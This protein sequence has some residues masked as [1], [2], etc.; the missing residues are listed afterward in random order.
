[1][2]VYHR[3]A[4]VVIAMLS[5][6][7]PAATGVSQTASE[8]ER[9]LVPI[10]LPYDQ[11]T[12]GAYGSVWQTE[13]VVRNETDAPAVIFQ[14]LCTYECR[15]PIP[16]TACSKGEPTQP[17]HTFTGVLTPDE[18]AVNPAIFLHV[19]K[20]IAN[21]G[22]MNLRLWERSRGTV[23]SGVEVPLVRDH[24]F[25]TGTSWLVNVPNQPLTSRIHLRVYFVSSPSR[26][27]EVRLRIYPGDSE[28]P[29][30]DHVLRAIGSADAGGVPPPG[31]Q[32]CIGTPAYAIEFLSPVL[33]GKTDTVR[34]RIDSL[35]PELRYWAMISVTSNETQYVT[36]VTPQ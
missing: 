17:Q 13:L 22:A 14:N 29:L 31:D 34:V 21:L 26:N 19:E 23:E 12:T 8:T 25:R 24:D 15:P 28:H 27:A 5:P 36:L 18:A 3:I 7:V 35:T 33:D 6:F 16:S 4:L 9:I 32:P 2:R 1:M 20:A 11:A 10:Y 30:A